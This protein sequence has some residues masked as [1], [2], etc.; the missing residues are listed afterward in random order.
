MV[1]QTLEFRGIRFEHLLDYLKQLNGKQ[2]TEEFP[3]QFVGTNWKAEVLKENEVQIT[4]RFHVN[5]VFIK[6]IASSEE[7]LDQLIASYRRKTFRAGG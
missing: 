5:A 7:D 3:Y 4:S 1:E 6:F 2:V